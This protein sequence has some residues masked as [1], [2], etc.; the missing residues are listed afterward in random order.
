MYAWIQALS[1]GFSIC[2]APRPDA[3]GFPPLPPTPQYEQE[4]LRVK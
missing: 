3:L 4:Q 1:F 2:G